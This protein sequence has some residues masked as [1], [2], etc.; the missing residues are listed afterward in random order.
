MNKNGKSWAEFLG[1]KIIDFK[2]GWNT[3]QEYECLL[4]NRG[5]FLNR[6]ALSII[7]VPQVKSR[8]E[9][10][11]FKSNLGKIKKKE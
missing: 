6:A 2:N 7:E 9:A 1:L 11:V 5:E 4:M 8:R 10:A 3:Q